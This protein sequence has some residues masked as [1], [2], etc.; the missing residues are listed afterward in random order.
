V[1]K[2]T[3]TI[4]LFVL[5]SL[6]AYG[7]NCRVDKCD[8]NIVVRGHVL[9]KASGKPIKNANIFTRGCGKQSNCLADAN[10]FFEIPACLT[11][12][13]RFYVTAEGYTSRTIDLRIEKDKATAEQKVELS[14]SS[15]VAGFVKNEAGE[16]VCGAV[17]KTFHFTNQPVETD[18][19]G[20][21]EIDGLDPVF[22]NYSIHVESKDYPAASVRFTPAEA[23]TTG[24]CD[25]LLKSGVTI[26]GQV[27]DPDGKAVSG[28]EVGDTTSRCM[29]NCT[30]SQTDANGYYRLRNI[31]KGELVLWA[32]H[33][34]YPPFVERF[35]IGDKD[36]ERRIDIRFEKP[37]PLRGKIV[38][39]QGNGI[40]GV[41]VGIREVKG[42]SNLSSY[43][44]R[45][46]TDK[47]GKFIIENAPPR[48][49]ITLEIWSDDVPNT[50]PE[51][52]TSK[53]EHVIEVD[54]AGK[55]YGRVVADATGEPVSKFNV[56]LGFSQKS[57][58]HASGY[59]STWSESGYNFQEPNGL[60]DTGRENL[61]IGAGY[62]VTVYSQG[63]DPLTID[64]VE[65]QPES[66]VPDREIFRL[67]PATMVPGRVFDSNDIAIAGATVRWFSE[68][69]RLYQQ[70]ERWDDGDTTMTD[71]EGRFSFNTI[72]TGK[73]GIYITARGYAP[74]VNSDLMIPDDVN[75][76]SRIVLEK[77]ANIV[78]TVFKEGCPHVGVEMS[79][80][81]NN[82]YN[83]NRMGY[84]DKRNVTDTE[85]NYTFSDLPGG[86]IRIYMMSP[87]INR[88]SYTLASKMLN[89]QPGETAR[90]D[91]GNEKGFML[92]GR[93]TMGQS[94]LSSALVSFRKE[95]FQRQQRFFQNHRT[96]K[97]PIRGPYRA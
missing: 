96:R 32:V 88:T 3:L 62:A 73:R 92:T 68:T 58:I 22:G 63:Y 34:E 81:L 76:L 71:V 5:L 2:T 26:Y 18:A 1:K 65:V 40:E 12:Y 91:F 70:G 13:F 87:A 38:D 97:G 8:T 49:R 28:A 4:C 59:S 21:Y 24:R 82:R 84:I 94:F 86:E 11:G 69:N 93:V 29:W 31:E 57:K 9:E 46:K 67:T 42:V 17:V 90:L 83:L 14:P 25:V 35:L 39:K 60:F 79:C 89:L 36:T 47:H 52:E 56:K 15:K 27:T 72:G 44:D 64:P 19:N 77:G 43:R 48:G 37:K 95:G 16:P 45:L 54:R 85:G 66:D 50:M 55:I 78:G 10:G 41:N 6:Q 20:F 30:E 74:Y 23:G 75:E 61:P 7:E 53:D 80:D 33:P 51:V